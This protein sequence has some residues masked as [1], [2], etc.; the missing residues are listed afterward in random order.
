MSAVADVPSSRETNVSQS[1]S[2]EAVPPQ[3]QVVAGGPGPAG[4]QMKRRNPV[5]AWLGLPIITLGIYG[6]VWYYLVHSELAAF[7][8][9]RPVSAG[10]A[11]CSV[12][13]GT[14]TLG[15]WPLITWVKLAGHIRNAQRAAG[16]QPSCSGAVGFLLGIFG[17]GVLYYQVEL[18]KVTK[19]YGDAP[20]GSPVPLAA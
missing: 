8:R 7:D 17:F 5:A 14:L 16:L 13:F 10:L 15:I 1:Y 3:D 9:R 12:L 11:V 6:I 18:N 4:T 2:Q 19:R 20:A